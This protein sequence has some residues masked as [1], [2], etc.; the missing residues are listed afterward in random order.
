MNTFH[1]QTCKF[2]K[3]KP[4]KRIRNIDLDN[5]TENLGRITRFAIFVKYYRFNP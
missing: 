1:K 5:L 4:W 2:I 3:R